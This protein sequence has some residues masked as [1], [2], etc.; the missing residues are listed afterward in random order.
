MTKGPSTPIN[1]AGGINAAQ[2]A[3]FERPFSTSRRVKSRSREFEIWAI[4]YLLKLVRAQIKE[5]G[6][7]RCGLV[8]CSVKLSPEV[9]QARSRLMLKR[10]DTSLSIAILPSCGLTFTHT[11][12]LKTRLLMLPSQKAVLKAT[13]EVV[14][15]EASMIV[16]AFD[17]SVLHST[18]EI[19]ALQD[20]TFYT[21]LSH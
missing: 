19:P 12:H 18:Q 8:R 10:T 4:T 13:L 21:I 2:S 15:K 7:E 14:G 20:K 1:N 11:A 3:F 16:N 9:A 6:L 5:S 17:G